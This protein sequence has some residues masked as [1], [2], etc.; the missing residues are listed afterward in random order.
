M[1]AR[2]NRTRLLAALVIAAWCAVVWSGVALAQQSETP[3]ELWQ[4]Y[5]L[6]PEPGSPEPTQD[7]SQGPSSRGEQV[8]GGGG[9]EE[10]AAAADEEQFPLVQVVP[11]LGLLALG[12]LHGVFVLARRSGVSERLG[13]RIGSVRSGPRSPR[14]PAYAARRSPTGSRARGTESHPKPSPPAAGAGEGA[15]VAELPAEVAEE[16]A[17]VAAERAPGEPAEVA[18]ERAEVAGKPA[19]SLKPKVPPA[20]P[21]KLSAQKPPPAKP[22]PAK[23]PP[24]KTAR[25]VKPARP[26]KPVAVAKRVPTAKPAQAATRPKPSSPASSKPPTPKK[27]RAERQPRREQPPP[28]AQDEERNGMLT[29]SIYWWRDGPVAD[30]YALATGLQ[31]R[32]WV[33]DRSPRFEWLAGDFPAEAREAHAALVEALVTAGWRHAGSEGVWYRQRFERPVAREAP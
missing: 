23:P 14:R 33:V 2:S 26:A 32:A 13:E 11:A 15:E 8:G 12:I 19:K 29:C 22:P 28:V 27:P 10:G 21:K 17:E 1:T 5:P 31:G 3:N 20:Q 6:N 30:F 4:E 24:A 25:V 16:P 9:G 7:V 18:T